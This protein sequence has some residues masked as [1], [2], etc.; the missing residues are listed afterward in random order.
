[1]YM[2][3]NLKTGDIK[4]SQTGQPKIRNKKPEQYLLVYIIVDTE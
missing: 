3:N 4:I 1:M 2:L